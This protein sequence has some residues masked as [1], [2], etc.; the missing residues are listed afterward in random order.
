MATLKA[1][2]HSNTKSIN[3]KVNPV[4]FKM[5][6]CN[7]VEFLILNAEIGQN[8]LLEHSHKLETTERHH[9]QR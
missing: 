6:V 9:F 4:G 5:K 7:M 2:G 8:A 1:F 3:R